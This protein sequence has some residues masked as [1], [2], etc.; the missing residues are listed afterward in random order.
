M[1]V[2]KKAVNREEFYQ[3]VRD[4]I[5]SQDGRGA[6]DLLAS[7]VQKPAAGRSPCKR[8]GMG[9]EAHAESLGVYDGTINGCKKED[10]KAC[11]CRG[12]C[13][14]NHRYTEKVIDDFR[15]QYRYLSNFHVCP[16]VIHGWTFPSSEHAFQAMKAT[17]PATW[18]SRF[19]D[20]ALSCKDARLL[21]RQIPM[22]ADWESVK[23]AYM[24]AIVF[25]KFQ[26]HA[27]IL[28]KLLATD[29]AMLVE[30]NT[31]GDRVW[32]VCDGVGENKL[33]KILME[34]RDLL[35]RPPF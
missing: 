21:G 24:K 8:C 7:Y 2:R 16:V 32:G 3:R 4:V 18:W 28:E 13:P 19:A 1:E 17:D 5:V 27:D 35:W 14:S 12:A 29:P 25:D 20:P 15:G 11:H 31:W 10:P 34:V 33:G 6:L 22:R 9:W 23:V 26:R 30:G